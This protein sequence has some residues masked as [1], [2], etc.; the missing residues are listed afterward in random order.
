MCPHRDA[1]TEELALWTGNKNDTS[2]IKTTR[3]E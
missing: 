2:R 1:A 3:P